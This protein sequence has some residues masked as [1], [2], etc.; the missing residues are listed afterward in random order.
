MAPYSADNCSQGYI[1]VLSIKKSFF[2]PEH[3]LRHG[4]IRMAKCPGGDF[5]A[6]DNPA[7]LSNETNA[8]KEKANWARIAHTPLFF[9]RSTISR[10]STKRR[11]LRLFEAAVLSK[12][13]KRRQGTIEKE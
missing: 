12:R 4:M 7:L 6:L 10:Q 5:L 2:S 3:F 13:K 9:R 11:E 1:E 8:S